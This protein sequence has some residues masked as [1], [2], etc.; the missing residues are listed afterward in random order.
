[1]IIKTAINKYFHIPLLLVVIILTIG[2]VVLINSR[3]II[4]SIQ[5][6][7]SAL[8]LISLLP[9]QNGTQKELTLLI[10]SAIKN[11]CQKYWLFGLLANQDG[12][13]D[14][15][16]NYWKNA[17][18][19]SGNFLPGIHNLAKED[20]TLAEFAVNTRPEKELS[21]LWLAASKVSE[22]ASVIPLYIKAL[23]IRPDN[24]LTWYRLGE[25]YEA[26]GSYD[27]AISA[28]IKSSEYLN[29]ESDFYV[30]V[31]RIYENLGEIPSAIYY[32]RISSWETAH[33]R[34]DL[35]ESQMGK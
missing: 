28:F 3:S 5:S 21:W 32:Y 4:S 31:G 30:R 17:I 16:D 1:M 33:Q 14:A 34:A 6:N 27:D 23:D 24:G 9:V 26:S 19:C 8:K 15:R 12:E 10:N 7:A 13:R 2:W 35:L 11:E 25:A 18:D 20:R 29:R 22:P